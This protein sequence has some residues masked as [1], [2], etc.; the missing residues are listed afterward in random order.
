[1]INRGGSILRRPK[2]KEYYLVNKVVGITADCA[3]IEQPFQ[4]FDSKEILEIWWEGLD[5]DKKKDMII[6]RFIDG[7]NPKIYTIKERKK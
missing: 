3:P 7:K 5:E 6:Y 1:M 4:I 2:V